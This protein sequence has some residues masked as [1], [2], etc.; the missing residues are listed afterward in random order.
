MDCMRQQLE[1]VRQSYSTLIDRLWSE[2]STLEDTI[3][4]SYENLV[5]NYE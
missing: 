5:Q 2:L 1:A 3:R 4:K